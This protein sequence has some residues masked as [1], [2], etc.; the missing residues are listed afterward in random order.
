MIESQSA[1]ATRLDVTRQ[2]V[3]GYIRAG[4]LSGASLVRE[5][6]RVMIDV[7]RATKQLKSTLDID[8]RLAN[9]KA[10][11]KPPAAPA[12][13]PV[14]DAAMLWAVLC[15]APALAAWELAEPGGNLQRCF[16]A[17]ANARLNIK[18]D[19]ML[20]FGAVPPG[21][22]EAVDWCGLAEEYEMAFVEPEAMRAD[23]DRRR[24]APD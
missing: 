9:G 4:Q 5:G 15:Q 21:E 16:D 24:T 14:A 12:P 6:R 20:R 23:W 7:E 18:G 1:F 11:L 19:L 22:F 2:C 17:F 3:N 8:Q 13:A 10:R